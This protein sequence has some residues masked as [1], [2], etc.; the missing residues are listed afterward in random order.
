MRRKNAVSLKS[1][2]R[3]LEIKLALA[4]YPDIPPEKVIDLIY[5]F[6]REASPGEVAAI[7]YDPRLYPKYRSFRSDHLHKFRVGEVA[8]VAVLIGI[9][10]SSAAV[11]ISVP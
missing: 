10:I 5:W 4:E 1:P 2:R 6:R 3:R 8:V 11:M 7:M 9:L